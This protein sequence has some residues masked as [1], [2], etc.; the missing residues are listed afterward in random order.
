[1]ILWIVLRKLGIAAIQ[2]F[3]I[4]TF[5]FSIM[6]VMPGDPVIL[7]LGAESNPTPEAVAAMRA[8]LG[9]DQPVL[10]QYASWLG[11]VLQGDF[12]RSVRDGYP[13]IDTIRANLPRTLELA[14]AAV[15]VATLIGVPLGIAAAL[16]RGKRLDV[17]LTSV[18][19]VGIS[20]PVYILG[21]MLILLFALQLD[22]LP[23]SGYM[24][25]DR[26]PAEHFRRLILPALTLG[27]GLSASIT[28]MTRS[29]VLDILDRDFVRTLR[30]KGTPERRIIWRHVLRNAAIPIVTIIGLQLGN[31]MGGT[32][33]VEA[34]FNW[35]GLS[36][37]L[38]EAVQSRNYPL[39]QGAILTIAG[40]YI[41]INLAVELIYTLLDPRVR[42]RR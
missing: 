29:S 26:N 8:R 10:T 28:R 23:S 16:N 15:I 40:V 13:V 3:V 5:V 2:L 7:L 35:P 22:W 39:V 30:A 11:G 19:T 4:A 42:R 20:V 27:F 36:T 21:A 24:R 37:V 9:L 33:L 18:S 14:V 17:V 41:L 38:V 32:V 6:Y 1:M 31:L 34:M 25:I 12:G